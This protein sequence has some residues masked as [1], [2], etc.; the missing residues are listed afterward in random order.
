MN[1]FKVYENKSSLKKSRSRMLNGGETE[2]KGT[3]LGWWER[4]K[5]PKEKSTDIEITIDEEYSGRPDLIS[6]DYYGVTTLMWLILQYNNIVD[7]EE[8]FTTGKTI[9]IPSPERA[10]TLF[11]RTSVRNDT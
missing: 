9:V 11:S 6:F 1:D 4:K 7:L 10:I 8:E 5:L 2:I 3:K